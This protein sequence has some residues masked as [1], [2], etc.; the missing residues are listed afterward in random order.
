MTST[1]TELR[2]GYEVR[3]G[4]AILADRFQDLPT[5]GHCGDVLTPAGKCLNVG[6]CRTADRQASR[7]SLRRGAAASA[8]PSAWTIGGRVD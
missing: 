5:C 6:T 1:L 2:T 4:A 3:A 7:Q 8:R